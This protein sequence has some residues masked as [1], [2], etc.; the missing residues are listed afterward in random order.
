MSIRIVIFILL[1]ITTFAKSIS[2]DDNSNGNVINDMNLHHDYYYGDDYIDDKSNNDLTSKRDPE[3]Y[4]NEKRNILSALRSKIRRSNKPIEDI[5][6]KYKF[7]PVLSVDALNNLNG[8]FDNLATN[9]H[10]MESRN[11][12]PNQIRLLGESEYRPRNNDPYTHSAAFINS[13]RSY[14]PSKSIRKLLS[15]QPESHR[16]SNFYDPMLVRIGLGR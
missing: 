16:N 13:I 11:L 3:I 8:F 15:Y 10:T 1:I 12:V 2:I 4:R 6:E 5:E 9:I 14:A 7:A